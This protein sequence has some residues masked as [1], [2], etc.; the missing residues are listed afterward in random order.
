[1]NNEIY[2]VSE[3]SIVMDDDLDRLE[4]LV[5]DLAKNLIKEI[6]VLR[7][8]K[9]VLSQNNCQ[10]NDPCALC[11]GR[12]DPCGL[13]FMLKGGWLVCD[14]C[15]ALYAPE[16]VAEQKSTIDDYERGLR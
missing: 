12:C 16:L 9:I 3:R 13:D 8:K 10:T 1:M 11:G 2:G 4:Y 15:A 6:R 7:S 5:K 14:R